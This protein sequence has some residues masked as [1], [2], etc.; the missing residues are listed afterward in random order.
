MAEQETVVATLVPQAKPVV[1]RFFSTLLLA[2]VAPLA[3][4]PLVHYLTVSP[5]GI[6]IFLLVEEWFILVGFAAFLT[7]LASPGICV[8]ARDRW[9]LLRLVVISLAYLGSLLG[10]IWLGQAIRRDAFLRL[11]A[12]SGPLVAA[13]RAFEARHG[14]PPE[15]L[16]ELTPEAFPSVPWTG[17]G[18]YP[19]YEYLHGAEAVRRFDGNPWVL[20]VNT[21]SGGINFDVFLYYPRQNYPRRGHGGWLEPL[22]GW[23]YVHE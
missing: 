12:R 8:F 11:A 18:A 22:A 19:R 13:I 2:S 3:C 7:V 10:G 6:W 23:A 1:W 9:Q 14:R 4:V 21:P 15:T 5:W 16:D 20:L 17:M